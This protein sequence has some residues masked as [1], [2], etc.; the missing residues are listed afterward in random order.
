[1]AKYSGKTN[2]LNDNKLEIRERVS[3]LR[4]KIDYLRA[5]EAL[6]PGFTERKIFGS[7]VWKVINFND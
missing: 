5:T 6:P 7:I 2:L 4:K 3:P 1:M